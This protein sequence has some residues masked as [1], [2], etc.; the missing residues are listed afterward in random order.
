MASWEGQEEL[1]ELLR[2][3]PEDDPPQDLSHLED[4]EEME[5]KILFGQNPGDDKLKKQV[6][7]PPPMH[8]STITWH[9]GYKEKEDQ[10]E[11][12]KLKDWVPDPSKMSKSTCMRMILSSEKLDSQN[13]VLILAEDTKHSESILQLGNG[14]PRKGFPL[15]SSPLL[16][17]VTPWPLSQDHVAPTLYSLLVAYCKS[18]LNQKLDPPK[19]LW[20]CLEDH[21][22]KRCMVTQFWVP[23]LGQVKINCYR[24]LTSLTVCQAVDPWENNNEERGHRCPMKP[25]IPCDHALCFKVIY[26]G[27]AWRPHDQKCWFIRLIAGHKHGFEELSPGDW[28]IL[29]KSRPYPYGPIGECP[30]LQYAVGVKMKV[31]GGPLTPKVLALKALSF[32]RVNICNM[33]N[34]GIGEGYPAQ[35][36]SHAL[37]AY[38][39]Q[40]G[41]SE[42]RVWQ[43]GVKLI[44]GQEKDYWCEYDHHGYFPVV[45]QPLS[46]TWARHAAPYG[47]Q[48]FATP[49]DLQ[50]FASELLPYGFSINTPTGAC[51]VSDRRLHPGNEGTLQEYLGNIEQTRRGYDEILSS[52]DSD[53]D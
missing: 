48:R 6:I 29:K 39:A 14:A 50:K 13:V 27:T 21:S 2:H 36:Y 15:T 9:F 19:W 34:P 4:L 10:Q 37:K 20:Q 52:D 28:E 11:N 23:P 43:T 31:T 17:V 12:I 1:R 33:D 35:G 38:G 3:L 7:K 5:P 46:P 16:P 30:N 18:F 25:R 24:N 51:Y 40:Y 47:I 32:H 26:E 42:E 44:G 45:P 22:G 49:Y 53:E 41:C 8:P